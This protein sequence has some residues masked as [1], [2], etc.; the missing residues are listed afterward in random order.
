MSEI[1]D[2]SCGV[3]L[4]VRL[5]VSSVLEGLTN[6]DTI[7]SL[8]DRFR[9]L[10]ANLEDFYRHIWDRIPQKYRT[11]AAR[12]LLLVECNLRLDP[13]PRNAELRPNLKSLAF[14]LRWKTQN[15]P[16]RLQSS[17]WTK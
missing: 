11:Q 4:W 16:S 3:F 9:E 5:P 13:D 8:Q 12:L 1:V 7:E 10:P 17:Q 2:T 15:L 14:L 6:H